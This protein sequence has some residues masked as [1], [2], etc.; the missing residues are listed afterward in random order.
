MSESTLDSHA[1]FDQGKWKL[2]K[3]PFYWNWEAF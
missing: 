1:N 3:I 2:A